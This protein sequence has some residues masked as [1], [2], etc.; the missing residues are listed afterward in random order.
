MFFAKPP[1][2]GETWP[3]PDTREEVVALALQIKGEN[4]DGTERGK[5]AIGGELYMTQLVPGSIL[6]DLLYRF[7]DYEETWQKMND[8][9]ISP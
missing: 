9:A 8:Y 3:A 7:P 2:L 5:V 1:P 4:G 6:T